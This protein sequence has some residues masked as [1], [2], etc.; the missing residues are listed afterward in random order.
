MNPYIFA[1][2][3]MIFIACLFVHVI[4]WR[5]R[6]PRNRPAAL[7]FTFLALPPLVTA[8]L[9]GLG[10][11]DAVSKAYGALSLSIT[12]WL[13]IYFLHYSLSM[14]YILSYPAIEAVSPTL[15]ITLMIGE[16]D[17]AGVGQ[18]ELASAFNDDFLLMPRIRDL[19]EARL[20]SER[21]GY[22]TIT[23]LGKAYAGG[24]II[25]RRLL[26]LQTGKG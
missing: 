4:V 17:G 7:F 20:V 16:A 6:F 9:Y 5:V 26:G 24:F 14:A 13:S 21:E 11:F 22:I 19:I 18:E 12:E 10:L 2:S 8:V 25:M 15:A 23:P 1:I 3:F